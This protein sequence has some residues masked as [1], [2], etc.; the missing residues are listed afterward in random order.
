MVPNRAIDAPG[1]AARPARQSIPARLGPERLGVSARLGVP[2]R[3]GVISALLLLAAGCAVPRGPVRSIESIDSTTLPN[4]QR[5]QEALQDLLAREREHVGALNLQIAEL[6]AEEGRLNELFI[7][8]EHAY[9]LLED[10]LASVEEEILAVQAD[11][12]AAREDLKAAKAQLK[13]LQA[14]LK[15]VQA[16]RVEME[17][18][19]QTLR[20]LVERG[21]VALAALPPETR[22]LIE[23]ELAKAAA[24]REAAAK[25]EAE[26]AAEEAGGDAPAEAAGGSGGG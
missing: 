3:L 2:V 21:R 23:E 5:S 12:Q 25:A 20:R 17:A 26:A 9:L 10:D 16:Q 18:A 4:L 24:E 1:R 7:E 6:R 11:I 22:T 13:A 8:S 15:Q 14:E 19:I